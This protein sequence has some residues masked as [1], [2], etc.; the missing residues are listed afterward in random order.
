MHVGEHR[1]ADLALDLLENSEALLHAVTAELASDERLA[2]SKD[3][4]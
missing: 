2:L 3:D 4:L 1:H